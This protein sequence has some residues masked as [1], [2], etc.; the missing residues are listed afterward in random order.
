MVVTPQKAK[1]LDEDDREKITKLEKFIDLEILNRKK[2]SSDSNFSIRIE[3]GYHSDKVVNEV[4]RMYSEAGWRINYDWKTFNGTPYG[5]A[6]ILKE[7][8]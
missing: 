2:H 3:V 5:Y 4:E 6:F 8:R 1:E 7:K